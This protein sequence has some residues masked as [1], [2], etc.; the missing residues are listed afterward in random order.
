[1]TSAPT[2][3]QANPK[4]MTIVGWVLSVLPCCM[5]LFSAFLKLS[6]DER[7]VQGFADYKHPDALPLTI[8][9]IEAGCTVLF[10]IPKTAVLGAVLLTGY[11]GGAVHVHV[12]LGAGWE[13]A[14]ALGVAIWFGLYFRDPRVRAL[15]PL[16]R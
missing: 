1:M 5:P 3:A 2:A 6:K 9:L 14:I 13:T 8:G 16:R 7:V 11:L 4:W 15:L 10:L 12:R